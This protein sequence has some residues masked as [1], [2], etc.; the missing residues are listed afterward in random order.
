MHHIITFRLPKRYQIPIPRVQSTTPSLA[1]A[2]GSALCS[3][4]SF[5]L[6]PKL[7]L[8]SVSSHLIH[9][10]SPPVS[11]TAIMPT[12][13]QLEQFT[14]I[15]GADNPTAQFFLSAHADN[16]DA[17]VS[18]YFE[19]DGVI[20]TAR[21]APRPPTTNR[22]PAQPP[23]LSNPP[24]TRPAR[25]PRSGVATVGSVRN[26]DEGEEGYYAGGEK[27]GQMIQDP[28]KNGR[29]GSSQ[30]QGAEEENPPPGNLAD[31]IFEQAR[32]RG[33]RTDAE[34]EQFEGPQSFSGAGYRLG[35]SEAPPQASRA[36]DVVNRRNVTRVLTF[37]R[38]GFT[39][40]DGELRR[41]EDPANE[42][43]LADVNRGVVPRD[44]EEP[45]IGDVSITLVDK[46]EEE[47]VPKKKKV[48]PFSG[49]GIRLNGAN[50]RE[51]TAQ[52][53]T[54][55]AE[56]A[57]TVDESAPIA[58]VQVRLSDGT[59]VVARLNETH[60]VAD[61]REFVRLSRAG[62]GTFTLSTT[63]PRK[64]LT[65]DALSL[66]EAGLNGAVVVQTLK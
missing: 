1:S 39:V 37:Y 4:P 19:S 51:V 48:V 13:Q 28:R 64:V 12:P 10:S 36:P 56:S 47:Y 18:A 25:Q 65:D 61:L 8:A 46:K 53:D 22:P 14:T 15:T 35:D 6:P 16:L 40:D 52:V 31:S 3:P 33:P 45:G 20:P 21:E 2:G 60:T 11:S 41:F 62:V 38:N 23:S 66:K 32:S 9:P 42:A 59:R 30:D 7:P 54:Q 34:R 57:V 43:F 55:T 27:S 50:A 26:D 63:F 49:G 5:F 44:L 24:P 58:T 29:A 17:A